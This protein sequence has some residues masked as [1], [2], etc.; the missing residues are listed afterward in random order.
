MPRASRRQEGGELTASEPFRKTVIARFFKA[1]GTTQL[2]AV[3]AMSDSMNDQPTHRIDRIAGTTKLR[4]RRGV[5]R[6]R[7]GMQA[8][9]RERLC[10]LTAKHLKDFIVHRRRLRGDAKLQGQEAENL[11]AEIGSAPNAKTTVVRTPPHFGMHPP[12]PIENSHAQNLLQRHP[13]C[14][15]KLR[16]HLCRIHRLRLSVRTSM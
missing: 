7:G 2:I 6:Q 12:N 14:S 15:T 1:N 4:A 16:D 3:F 5:A 8:R 11:N 13:R 10:A 9:N